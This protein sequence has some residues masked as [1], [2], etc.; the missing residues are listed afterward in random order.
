MMLF[1]FWLWSIVAR[2]ERHRSRFIQVANTWASEQRE[3]DAR[4][5]R[6]RIAAFDREVVA[7]RAGLADG[8][9]GVF[10]CF[11][12]LRRLANSYAELRDR[13][14]S[15]WRQLVVVL[16]IFI[17]ITK[18][19][20]AHYFIPSGSGEPTMVV[21]D[22]LLGNKLVYRFSNVKRGEYIICD[23]PTF[24]YDANPIRRWWQ[25]E[26]GFG[27][28]LLGLPDGPMAWTKLIIGIPGDTIEGRSEDCRAVIY[29]NGNK[30]DEPY[31]NP[32]PLIASV[33]EVGFINSPLLAA[34]PIVSCLARQLKEAFYTYDDKV[35]FA[36]QPFYKLT[37]REVIRH[38]STGLPIVKPPYIAEVYDSFSPV[39]LPENCYWAMG[40]SRRNSTDSR[41]WGFLPRSRIRGRVS[42]VLFSIDTEESWSIFELVKHP[43]DFWLKKFRWNRILKKIK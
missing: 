3:K 42:R 33:R 22:H 40:D 19:I 38:P 27:I 37:D 35:S 4:E 24:K 32:Y 41:F 5:V 30:L 12:R 26:V 31:V 18:F 8:S 7:L 2:F 36:Q 43:I 11:R 10:N 23:D 28:G 21:G 16:T 39:V 1:N 9:L 34:I 13:T 15:L 25:Q 17:F 29:L 14:T 20:G 6:A